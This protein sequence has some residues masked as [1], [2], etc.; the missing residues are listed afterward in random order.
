MVHLDIDGLFKEV[1]LLFH[2][3]AYLIDYGYLYIGVQDL[4]FSL[5]Y[6]IIFFVFRF[7]PFR[8]LAELYFD[9]RRENFFELGLLV[10]KMNGILN[11]EL[12]QYGL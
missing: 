9:V 1:L 3:Q 10:D 8:A 12:L 2:D 11:F 7:C 6:L 5:D 4:E